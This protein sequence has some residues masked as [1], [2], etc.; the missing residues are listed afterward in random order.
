MKKIAIVDTMFARGDMGKIAIDTI[1]ASAK[2]N[3]WKVKILRKTVPGVKDLPVALLQLLEQG[4]IAAIALGMPGSAPVD[5]T[6]SHEA[7]LG[8]GQVQLMTGKTVLE[9]FVHED[10]AKTPQELGKIMQNRAS[11]H[12]QNLMWM[13]FAPQ[14]ITKRAGTGER[15]GKENAAPVKVN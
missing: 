12:A 11:K 9:V 2:A 10:E 5:K 1:N 7:S 4:C 14:E 15:Q 8:I 13:L 6:C 3:K